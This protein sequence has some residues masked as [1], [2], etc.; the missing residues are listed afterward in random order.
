MS[1]NVTVSVLDLV[2]PSVDDTGP[3]KSEYIYVILTA[4]TAGL[5]IFGGI[6]ICILYVAFKD[7]RSPGRQ[8]LLYLAFS[9]ALLAL[10][11]LLGVV[12]Y[13]YRDSDVIHRS[14]GYC[15]FQ[16]AMTIYFS[17]SSFAWTVTM[18]VCLFATVVLGKSRFTAT[19]MKLFHVIA[20]VPA[21][22]YQMWVP[23][24]IA[25]PLQP[26]SDVPV[27]CC[28]DGTGRLSHVVKDD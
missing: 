26:L 28:G 9:D 13:L 20:W 19:Y 1:D 16:S 5:S 17:L 10:G 25:G 3:P 27:P 15:D 8:L 18:A 7:L 6:S 4:I 2:T 12:W 11:N 22:K 14:D 23:G 24:F 21:G